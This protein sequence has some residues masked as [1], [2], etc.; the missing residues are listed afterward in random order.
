MAAAESPKK[1]QRF[2]H[3]QLLSLPSPSQLSFSRLNLLPTHRYL[4][5]IITQCQLYSMLITSLDC[6]YC[7]LN[8]ASITTL[9]SCLINLEELK[10][11]DCGLKEIGQPI[12]W[13]RRLRYIDFSRNK[14]SEVPQGLSSLQYLTTL[15]LSGNF[16]HQLDPSLLRLPLLEKLHLVQNPIQNVPKKI[17]LEGVLKLREY[18]KTQTLPLP[19]PD[20]PSF[21]INSSLPISRKL[22][23]NSNPERCQNLRRYLLRQQGSFDSGYESG[24]RCRSTSASSV[25]T[26]DTDMGDLVQWPLF[27]RSQLPDGYSPVAEN[28]L[29]QIFL[30]EGCKDKVSIE[31]V[32]DL[33]LHPEVRANEL[34]ITP[35]V[36]ITP[37]GL[38]FAMEEPAI[39]VLPHC[40]KPSG[41]HESKQDLV[42][43]YSNS[44]LNQPPAWGKL[45]GQCSCEIFQDYVLF[46]TTHF[47]LFAV[48]LVQPYPSAS[49]SIGPDYGGLLTVP[50]LPGFEVNL[51][52]T[53]GEE[54]T[55]TASVYYDDAPYNNATDEHTLASSCVSIEPHGAQFETPVQITLPIP[56]YAEIL[57]HFPSAKLELWCAP[58]VPSQPEDWERLQ[59]VNISIT[60]RNG[61]YVLTFT[62]THFSFWETLWDIGRRALQK[63]GLGTSISS[64]RARYVSVRVQAFMSL[65]VRAMEIQTF[66]LLVAVYKFGT[67]LS[68]LSN[69]PWPLLDTGSKRIY[70]QL[71]LLEVSIQ[72]CFSA[73]EYED[74][75]NPLS[76]STELIEFNGDDFCQRFEFALQLRP[77]YELHKG[78][79]MGKLHFKQWNGSTPHRQ[80]Y[81]LIVQ[82]H[83]YVN[84]SRQVVFPM[85]RWA[86]C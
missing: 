82:V 23:S 8:K 46:K 41:S 5:A 55:V 78:M 48:L 16:I 9:C 24:Q 83:V 25:D 57:T 73:L 84:L 56:D 77:G 17:C 53:F 4:P 51:P 31:L 79:L 7:I 59:N 60:Q 39:V 68:H 12:V 20:S 21:I 50:E 3:N 27:E 32:K 44:G 36:H 66:G 30:P 35:V 42:P 85:F 15:N 10:V 81:N 54:I 62:T 69:Y 80:N 63:L 72:G 28:S 1:L 40:T 71:G 74:P 18:F 37:H 11:V 33:S 67:P 75:T 61:T 14:L 47:S 43:V 52:P 38:N 22:S 2:I 49:I 19:Q 13:P 29:C 64:F 6:H 26:S 70:L 58:G 76:R 34:L 65:P 45:D 86:L